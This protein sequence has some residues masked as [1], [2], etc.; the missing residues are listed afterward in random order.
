M[1]QP[2]ADELRPKTLDEVYGQEEI[3]GPGKLLRRL[4]ESGHVPNLIFYGPSGTG[5]TTVAN[6]I[7]ERTKRKLY[8]LNAT[9]AS[10]ADIKEIVA[11]LDTFLAPDGVLLYLDEIQSFN[12]KQQQTLLGAYGERKDHPHRFDDGEPVFLCLQCDARAASTVFEFKP[13]G[14]EAAQQAVRRA[15]RLY[16]GKERPCACTCERG[17]GGAH[18]LWLAAATC[19]R[20][21]MRWRCYSRRRTPRQDTC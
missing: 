5:K 13:I 15:I 17:G 7:A 12:K 14:P 20:R 3:L 11:Q 1:Y 4:I 2:L 10:T 21:S 9:T 6:I 8:K 18:R 19:A 16:G